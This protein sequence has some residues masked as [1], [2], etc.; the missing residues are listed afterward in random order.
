MDSFGCCIRATR[1]QRAEIENQRCLID[2]HGSGFAVIAA[3]FFEA[4]RGYCNEQKQRPRYLYQVSFPKEH[5]NISMFICLGI[6]S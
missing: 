6:K 1:R 5:F 3:T 4:E 2:L